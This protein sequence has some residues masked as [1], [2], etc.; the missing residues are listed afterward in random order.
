MNWILKDVWPEIENGNL[1]T[2]EDIFTWCD[3]YL[4]H[5]YQT[6]N[7]GRYIVYFKFESES[8][9]MLFMLKWDGEDM[10]GDFYFKDSSS[11]RM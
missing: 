3:T 9:Q 6:K 11:Y 4:E 5:N 8:D 2:Q 7:Q 1:E 10:S